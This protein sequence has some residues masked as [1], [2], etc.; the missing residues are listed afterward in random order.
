VPQQTA[1]GAYG[2]KYL[3]K[4]AYIKDLGQIAFKN[5]PNN[6]PTPVSLVFMLQPNVLQYLFNQRK[7]KNRKAPH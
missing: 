1:R 5:F 7:L 3:S 4:V 2:R 6:L